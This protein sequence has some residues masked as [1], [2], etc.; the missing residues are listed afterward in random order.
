MFLRKGVSSLLLVVLIIFISS[1]KVS[2]AEPNLPHVTIAP[3][4]YIFYSL[5]RLTEKALI[6]TKI[7]KDSKVDFLKELF[8]KRLA[9]LKY[10]VDNKLLGEIQ[11]SSQRLSY[12]VGILSDYIKANRDLSKQKIDAENL[13]NSYQGLLVSLRDK[14][15]ANSSYWMLIQHDINSININLEKFK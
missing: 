10:V 15:P 2:A 8:L 1:T 7:T 6:F 14:Y 9:E 3:D 4:N 13:L 12:Q 5:T 11:Q